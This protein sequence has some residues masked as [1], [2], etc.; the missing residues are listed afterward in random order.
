MDSCTPVTRERGDIPPQIVRTPAH[1]ILGPDAGGRYTPIHVVRD[2]VAAFEQALGRVT[3]ELEQE[4]FR[5][6]S[7]P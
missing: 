6:T 5:E 7:I 1:E 4:L 3:R 2:L